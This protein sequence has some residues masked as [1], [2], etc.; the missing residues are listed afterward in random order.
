MISSKIA[1]AFSH[2]IRRMSATAAAATLALG[3]VSAFAAS[4][5]TFDFSA[6]SGTGSPGSFSGATN[7]IANAVDYTT[8]KNHGAV[9][10]RGDVAL[11]LLLPLPYQLL[12]D[13]Q[14]VLNAYRAN[15]LGNPD[16]SSWNWSP[17]DWILS[18][19][20]NGFGTL[21]ILAYSAWW[22]DQPQCV[23]PNPTP[24]LRKN[25]R[26]P[27]AANWDIYED[28]VKKIL[29]RYQGKIDAIEVWNEPD[30]GPFLEIA[31]D[32]RYGGNNG[33]AAYKDI[34]AHAAQAVRSVNT[35]VPMGGPVSWEVS[36]TALIF[37]WVDNMLADPIL[38]PN[39]NFLS[40]HH[41]GGG[42]N[43]IS[44]AVTALRGIAANRNKPNIPMMVTEW[45]YNSSNGGDPVNTTSPLAIPF[46]AM[47]LTEMIYAGVAANFIYRFNR[48]GDGAP[49]IWF[50][51][52]NTNGT[53]TYKL[54]AYRLLSSA[55]GLGAAQFN[56]KGRSTTNGAA[57]L[58]AGAAVNAAGQNVAWVANINSAT[59]DTLSVT[60]RG[61]Q[62]NA[63][64]D[65]KIYEASASNDATAPL[66]SFPITANASG[67]Y[68]FNGAIATAT[69]AGMVL[70]KA[71]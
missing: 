60:F 58:T 55:L 16:T 54:R 50:E 62:P 29:V 21:A 38:S 6:N 70:T 34:Y 7:G 57:V 53:P 33:L 37:G 17:A 4:S 23:D 20:A 32:T 24:Y 51:S 61:L 35:T 49:P 1:P 59:G 2:F 48:I 25:T 52:L 63:V 65:L 44:S 43:E 41:Y 47:R 26:V 31:C 22:L 27:A 18:A 5:V 64:Y 8:Y 28:M 19:K 68:T 40:F 12:S 13:Q 3:T 69:L 46:V 71:P 67:I 10:L 39:I 11:T 30:N 42:V 66:V 56:L 15:F 9:A 45:N 14:A 36:S